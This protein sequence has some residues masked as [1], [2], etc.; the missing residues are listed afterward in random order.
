MTR[1]R[2]LAGASILLLWFLMTG[3]RNGNSPE[4]IASKF[5]T[6]MNQSD[7]NTA[8]SFMTK[9]AQEVMNKSNSNSINTGGGSFTV[10]ATSTQGEQASVDVVMTDKEKPEK[11][12]NGKVNLRLEN[13]EWRVFALKLQI[14]GSMD[15]TLDFEHP[16]ASV[17][18]LLGKIVGE[19]AK[20]LGKG[21]GEI[22]HGFSEGLKK[23]G[24]G[25]NTPSA[26][27]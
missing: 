7:W 22:M 19:G 10:G 27:P 2:I 14:E 11:K 9:K 23:A 8:K 1:K 21:M 25:K 18:E 16:E 12:T 4:S 20:A 6:A 3:C 5:L 15:F 24:E 13:G 26:K 17:G